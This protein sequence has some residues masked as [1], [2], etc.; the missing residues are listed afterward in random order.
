VNVLVTYDIA[1]DTQA[2]VKRLVQV[3]KICES[4]G[5]RV[6]KSV[7][8]CRL[9]NTTL[10]QLISDLEDAIEP[11]SDSVNLY[12]LAADDQDLRASL[13]RKPSTE[14]HGAWIV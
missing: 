7:F 6:Q 11:H 14:P 9:S 2:G 5:I 3:A 12:R 8:E 1:T 13:G 4:Y 10:R